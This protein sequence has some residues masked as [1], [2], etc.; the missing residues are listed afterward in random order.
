MERLKSRLRASEG[1]R[2]RAYRDSV[3]KLTIAYGHNLDAKGLSRRAGDVILTDD[4][5]DAIRDLEILPWWKGLSPARQSVLADMSFNLGIRGLLTFRNTLESMRKGDYEAA[6][7]G[8][9]ASK[10]AR[11]VGNRAV[12]LARIMRTGEYE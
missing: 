11:Q 6:A 5:E 2:S 7:N 12:N 4:V 10:W 3:G 9:L 8:M 1:W